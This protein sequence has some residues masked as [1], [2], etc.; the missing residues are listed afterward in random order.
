M[1]TGEY[2]KAL[3]SRRYHHRIPLSDGRRS[4][5]WLGTESLTSFIA[6]SSKTPAYLTGGQGRKRLL[7]KLEIKRGVREGSQQKELRR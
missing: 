5:P 2:C 1:K 3:A 6:Y 7:R 4:L